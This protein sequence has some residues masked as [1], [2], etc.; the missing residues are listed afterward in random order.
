MRFHFRTCAVFLFAA[1]LTLVAWPV[2]AQEDDSGTM[3]F[4]EEEAKEAQ[5][6]GGDSDDSAESKSD[7]DGDGA[8]TF[9]EEAAEETTDPTT[10]VGVVVVPNDAISESQASTLRSRLDDELEVVRNSEKDLKLD[11]SGNTLE[12]LKQ[13]TVSSCVTEP[14]C[15][16]SVGRKA[17]VDRILL[18]RVDEDA[19][20]WSLD[21]DYFD[22][23]NTLFL[24]YHSIE[25]K[26]NFRATL[27]QLDV[28]VR[29][30][31]D[32]RTGRAGPDYYGGSSSKAL[33]IIGISSGVISVGTLVAGILVGTQAQQMEDDLNGAER[34]EAGVYQNYSQQEALQ[35]YNDAQTRALTANVLY[36][37][38]AGFALTGGAL[39]LTNLPGGDVPADRASVWER[40][41]ITPRVGANSAGI[42]ASFEF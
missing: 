41:N 25:N 15:L 26:P 28:A 22:V 14:L 24:R 42:G 32:L 18:A 12:A 1:T 27:Q 9:T 5:D 16:A 23:E 13:R 20:E 10:T 4:G 39:L 31:F 38:S 36:G 21:L 2:S 40:L 6:G 33:R 3:T 11:M 35:T 30:V 29:E 19:G 34:N 17:K 8:M 37:L 7:S